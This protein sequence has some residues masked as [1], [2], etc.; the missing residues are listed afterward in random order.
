[1]TPPWPLPPHAQILDVLPSEDV[2]ALAQWAIDSRKAFRP[3]KVFNNKLAKGFVKPNER[4]AL[5]TYDLGPFG[6]MLER[7]MWELL[8]DLEQATRCKSDAA[9]IELELAAHGDGAHFNA[10]L[11]IPYGKDRKP[12]GAEP[13]MDRVLSAVYYFHREPKGFSGGELRLFRF[14]ARPADRAASD[15]DWVDV[16]PVQNSLVAFPS[17]ALHEVRTVHCPSQAFE[18]Y[19][20]AINC[21]YC[22]KL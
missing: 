9:A 19:R 21:W 5:I 18:D 20:F 4:V 13:G 15:D 1:M 2:R 3:A 6:E 10:H 16:A 22:R 11:D 14:G 12:L 7:R 17:W 8:P